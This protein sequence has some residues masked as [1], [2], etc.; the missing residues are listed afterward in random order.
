MR[1][2]YFR[3]LSLVEDLG[4]PERFAHYR[5]TRRAAPIVEA[6]LKPR[7]ATMVIAPY[8][9]GKSLAAGVGALAVRGRDADRTVVS[10]IAASMA[11]VAP[12]VG[13]R[14]RD[15]LDRGATGKVA[16]LSG[17]HPDPLVSIARQLDLPKAPAN[18]DGLAKA[19]ATLDVDHVAIVWD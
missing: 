13:Q 10:D 9:S 17:Y 19:I 7:A 2:S 15:R 18:L 14:L 6:V 16:I 3:S 12:D 1:E 4:K 5:P 11:L 8:G